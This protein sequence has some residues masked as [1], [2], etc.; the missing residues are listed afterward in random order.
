MFKDRKEAGAKLARAL[1]KYKS[2][3]TIVL[4]IPRGGVEVGLEIADQLEVDFAIIVV[5]KLPFPDNPESGFGAI[6]ED[7]STFIVPEA[8]SWI[9][10]DVIE[11]VKKEQ[12]SEI[13][14]RIDVLRNRQP[15][16]ELTGKTVILVDDGIAMGSTMNA[17]IMCC[18]HK[19]A[20]E[21]IVAAPVSAA[22]RALQMAKT[23]DAALVL[24]TPH[25]F[26][27]VAQAYENWYD[28]PDSEVVALMNKWRKRKPIK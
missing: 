27:A 17:A 5:R 16:P 18:R 19:K 20:G 1:R 25:F 22:D 9:S 23:A 2:K 28:V 26:Q 4:G 6:A 24:E 21:V 8:A 11:E 15:L 3:D 7:G 13:K 14:R 10:A 12:K